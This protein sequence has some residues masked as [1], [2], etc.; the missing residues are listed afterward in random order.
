MAVFGGSLAPIGT[1]FLM[2][3]C[4]LGFVWWATRKS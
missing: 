4:G 3:L 1:M 2:F